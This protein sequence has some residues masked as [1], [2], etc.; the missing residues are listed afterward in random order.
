M[1]K[2]Y[3]KTVDKIYIAI[4]VINSATSTLGLGLA[5]EGGEGGVLR[6][7]QAV[8]LEMNS[9]CVMLQSAITPKSVDAR[10]KKR[11]LCPLL[12][13]HVVVW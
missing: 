5:G 12:S 8:Y 7:V 13:G 10:N 1:K 11:S 3:F 9:I 6:Y 4:E 2:T